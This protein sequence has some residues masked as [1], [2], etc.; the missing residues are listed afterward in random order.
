MFFRNRSAENRPR[1]LRTGDTVCPLKRNGQS[2]RTRADT[3]RRLRF[4]VT[5]GVRLGPWVKKATPSLLKTVRSGNKQADKRRKARASGCPQGRAQASH[6]ASKIIPERRIQGSFSVCN[7]C[8]G[9]MTRTT[10]VP[11]GD[12]GEENTPSPW[13]GA[14]PQE[15][16]GDGAAGNVPLAF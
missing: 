8:D 3:D 10:E 9:G 4:A 2:G 13:P 14:E 12:G 5:Q 11:A 15:G 6:T 1:S 16:T 7:K